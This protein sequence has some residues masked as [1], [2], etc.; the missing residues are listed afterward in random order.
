[1]SIF[2]TLYLFAIINP[3]CS[4][5]DKSKNIK[6]SLHYSFVSDSLINVGAFS[7]AE[8]TIN[9][10]LELDSNNYVAYNNLGIL[11]LKLNKPKDE[12]IAA[13]L[14][15]VLIKPDYRM[16]IFNL[17]NYYHTTGDYK[18]SIKYSDKYIGLVNN[19]NKNNDNLAHI[20]AL[21]GEGKNYLG[22]YQNAIRDLQNAISL[23]AD[24]AG[25]YKELGNSYRNLGDYNNAIKYYSKAIELKPDYSQAYGGRGICY[26]D[27]LNDF[28]KALSDYSKAIEL[29]PKSGT[30]FFNR[31]ALLFD[32]NFKKEALVDLNKADSLGKTDAKEYLKKYIE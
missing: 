17:V 27:G 29:N 31:G 11:Y 15:S 1:M 10:A 4:Q 28:E 24:D 3:G 12:I 7:E 2:V 32:H 23:N 18:N 26:D 5:N 30:Y 20:W 22:N 6:E 13:F 8:L 19:E 16:G 21:R 9:K 14:K 25:A